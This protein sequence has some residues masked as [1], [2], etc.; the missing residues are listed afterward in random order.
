MRICICTP[1]EMP[2]MG[3]INLHARLLPAYEPHLHLDGAN[4]RF[5]S[6]QLSFHAGDAMFF[7]LMGQ[8]VVHPSAGL[9][10]SEVSLTQ[11][12]FVWSSSM[13]S[14]AFDVSCA[15]RV[16]WP[17]LCRPPRAA[18]VAVPV[19]CH[20]WQPLVSTRWPGGAAWPRPSFV[21]ALSRRLAASLT[22]CRVSALLA[23]CCFF[24]FLS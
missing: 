10:R 22:S 21:A 23:S 20:V 7:H 16:L 6:A 17:T 24:D 14:P 12:S 18:F 15:I 19:G 11:V 5:V 4:L 8:F 9:S 13:G 2:G 1:F 3:H